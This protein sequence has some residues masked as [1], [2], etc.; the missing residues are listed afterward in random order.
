MLWKRDGTQLFEFWRSKNGRVIN[1]YHRAMAF[2]AVEVRNR[3]PLDC[4]GMHID[5][6]CDEVLASKCGASL[7]RIA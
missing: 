5:L 4:N 7:Y 1:F 2:I 3:A 6:T